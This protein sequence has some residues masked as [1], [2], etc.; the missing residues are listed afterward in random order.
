MLKRMPTMAAVGC[1]GLL[2][3]AAIGAVPSQGRLLA[4]TEQTQATASQSAPTQPDM[5]EMMKHHQQMMADMKAA[6]GKL[7]DLVSAMNAETGEAKVS[8]MAA[9]VTELAHRQKTMHERMGMMDHQM[10]MR[11]MGDRGMMRK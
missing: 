3:V 4:T 6:D 5:A 2:T 7:D 11:M 8:A 1:V 10:M 9:V